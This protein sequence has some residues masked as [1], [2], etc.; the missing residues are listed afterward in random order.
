MIDISVKQKQ[1]LVLDRWS[2]PMLRSWWF[3]PAEIG[4]L[5]LNK[6]MNEYKRLLCI[7]ISVKSL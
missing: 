2:L 4:R 7:Q 1:T 6:T 3:E 5:E